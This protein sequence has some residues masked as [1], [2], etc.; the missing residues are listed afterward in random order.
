M[1]QNDNNDFWKE[2]DYILDK[3]QADNVGIIKKKKKFI[4]EIIILL[5]VPPQV[6]KPDD[7]LKKLGEYIDE[8][9]DYQRLLYSEI[10]FSWISLTDESKADGR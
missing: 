4:K 5:K 10:T 9:G 2:L 6:Y 3:A 1:N 7:F 8:N